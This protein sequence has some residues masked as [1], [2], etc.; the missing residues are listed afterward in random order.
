VKSRHRM[1][2][3]VDTVFTARRLTACALRA[4]DLDELC[5]LW[6]DPDI[7]KCTGMAPAE[8]GTE[9]RGW[10]ELYEYH[11]RQHSWMGFWLL[12]RHDGQLVGDVVIHPMP[13]F[14][15]AEIGWHLGSRFRGMGYASEAVR[16]AV[17]CVPQS[18]AV[19]LWAFIDRDNR[20]SAE[21]ARR[22]DFSLMYTD[23]L[24]T[25][26]EVVDRWVFRRI[27]RPGPIQDP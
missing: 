7:I 25:P 26:G 10:P 8:Y 5:S 21:V 2:N 27:P 15:A 23:D 1:R 3:W 9:M 14:P 11:N 17:S 13:G 19:D 18:T 24:M 22:C 16:A 4:G 6:N 20:A 12:R